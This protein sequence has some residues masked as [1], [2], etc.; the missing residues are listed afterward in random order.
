MAQVIWAPTAL[1]DAQSIAEYV[2]RDSADQAA[3]LVRRFIEAADRL[4]EFPQSGRIIPEVADP[5]CR[6]VVVG[7]YRVMYRLEVGQVWIT[8]IVHGARDWHP[9]HQAG[10]R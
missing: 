6:E 3:L 8:G 1:S 10:G 5:D 9:E 7:S 2:A 4:A